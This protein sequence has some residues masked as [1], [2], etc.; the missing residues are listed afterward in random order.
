MQ[1]AKE[2]IYKQKF[3]SSALNSEK[4]KLKKIKG[5]EKEILTEGSRSIQSWNNVP[6]FHMDKI[7]GKSEK[8]KRQERVQKILKKRKQRGIESFMNESDKYMSKNDHM[9]RQLEELSKIKNK[10]DGINNCRSIRNKLKR[11][12][13]K[14]QKEIEMG[15]FGVPKSYHPT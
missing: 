5:N 12:E 11:K 14:M 13:E 7:M 15:M 4:K 9:E 10:H 2:K 6:R 1:H 3:G 8:E